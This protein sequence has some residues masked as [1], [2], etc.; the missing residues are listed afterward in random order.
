MEDLGLFTNSFVSGMVRTM[1]EHVIPPRFNF[2]KYN[3]NRSGKYIRPFLMYTFPFTH[4]LTKKDL[5]FMWQNLPPDIALDDYNRDGDEI[6]QE[7]RNAHSIKGTPIE[8]YIRDGR[9]Q[10]IQWMVFK[11]KRSAEKNYFEKMNTDRLPTNHPER[12][13]SEKDLFKYGFNWPY[14]Y[15]SLVELIKIDANTVFDKSRAQRLENTA[16]RTEGPSISLLEE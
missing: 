4:T 12:N 8:Q 13:K 11:V 7:V 6:K 3:D 16:Q 15:F 2:L 9:M 5:G 10:E 1:L 14:D